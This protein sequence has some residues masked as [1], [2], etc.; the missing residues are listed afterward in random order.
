MYQRRSRKRENGTEHAELD[1]S[2]L[3]GEKPKM[4]L[5]WILHIIGLLVVLVIIGLIVWL[6][7][8]SYLRVPKS[9]TYQLCR[10]AYRCSNQT[11][12]CPVLEAIDMRTIPSWNDTELENQFNLTRACLFGKCFYSF[13]LEMRNVDPR[14]FGLGENW[15]QFFFTD[16]NNTSDHPF[17]EFHDIF[18][19]HRSAWSDPVSSFCLSFLTKSSR[20]NLAAYLQESYYS[21]TIDLIHLDCRYSYDCYAPFEFPVSDSLTFPIVTK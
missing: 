18:I 19:Y 7:I 21:N 10:D 14:D 16:Q 8:F 1:F 6:L 20:T 4:I 11:T 3:K 9:G 17:P 5:D 2:K 15:M 13:K 12:D